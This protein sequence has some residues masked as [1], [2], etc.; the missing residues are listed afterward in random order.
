MTI[1]F[2]NSARSFDEAAK[3]VRFLGYDGMFEIRFLVEADALRMEPTQS[4]PSER[5]Y[6]AAFDRIRTRIL[7]VAVRVYASKRKNLIVLGPADFR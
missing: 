5:D 7:E 4:N 2:P 6:L 3:R 1:T